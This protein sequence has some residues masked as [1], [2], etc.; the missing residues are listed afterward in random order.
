M[1]VR[2]AAVAATEH[3]PDAPDRP[4]RVYFIEESAG[5]F[6]PAVGSPGEA[7]AY[8]MEESAGVFV[9]TDTESEEDRIPYLIDTSTVIL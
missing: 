1:A 2:Q 8:V 6:V 9:L 3:R 5:V 7:D 4:R